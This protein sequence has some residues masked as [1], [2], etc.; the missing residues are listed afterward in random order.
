M[1]VIFIGGLFP[2]SRK[3]EFI[4][5]S[6]GIIQ[7]AANNF[8]WSFIKGLGN[9]LNEMSIYT[10]PLLGSFPRNYKKIVINS[11][12]FSHNGKSRDLCVG[13]INLPL[14]SL[15]SKC[16][17]M[18]RLLKRNNGTQYLIVYSVHTPYLLAAINYK[19]KYP[20]SKI[21]LIVPDLPEYMSSNTG[22]FYVFL[23]KIDLA[24]IDFLVKRVDS[25]VFITDKMVSRF[26]VGS[27][28]WVRIEGM[29]DSP[30]NT[31]IENTGHLEEKI[32][33]YAGTLDSR[34]GILDLL[35]SF[36]LIN[37]TD[38]RLWVCGDGNMKSKVID[39][40]KHDYRIKYFG[41]ITTDEVLDLQNKATVLVNPRT[42]KG[43][44]TKYSFPIKTMGYLGSGKPTIMHML[45]GIPEEYREYLFVPQGEDVISLKDKIVEVCTNYHL[46]RNHCFKCQQFILNEKNPMVQTK[47]IVTLLTL[48]FND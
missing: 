36:S 19:R 18:I 37:S 12:E 4:S 42:S 23:K 26:N 21:C 45:P 1:N 40:S 20:K 44:Y 17:N 43:E 34:Y 8:Q 13:F 46:Y 25:F 7:F 35:K 9:Y 31:A 15:I 29:Y 24:I 11:S 48:S 30:G 3:K 5:N 27:R 47:K 38:Y 10:A 6:K 16:V 33:L 41:Q 32:I 2:E 14:L 22:R 28:P 39:Y